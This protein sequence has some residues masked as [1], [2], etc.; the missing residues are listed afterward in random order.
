MSQ[1]QQAWTSLEIVKLGA[2]LLTPTIILL[3]GI[4]VTRL[5]EQFKA[6]LWANQKVIEKRIGVYDELAPL[7]NDLYCYYEFVGNWKEFT[8]PQIIDIKRKLDKKVYINA[9]LFSPD[10]QHLY[11]ALIHRCFETYVGLGLNAKLRTPI[12]SE[13]GDRRVATQTGWDSN[14]NNMFSNLARCPTKA[15]IRD[16]YNDL[17]SRF[18]SELGIGLK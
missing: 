13:D 3:L 9:P 4:W 5:A 7:L 6:V 15:E 18:S 17:M 10:F 11:D 1:T 14:W 2:S 12:S 8:P 16:T